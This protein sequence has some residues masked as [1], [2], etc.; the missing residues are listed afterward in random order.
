MPYFDELVP[1][2][3]AHLAAFGQLVTVTVGAASSTLDAIVSTSHSRLGYEGLSV[4]EALIVVSFASQAFSATGAGRGDSVS[5]AGIAYTIS[6]PP[7]A[8]D[9]GMTSCELR[10]S[11]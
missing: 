4:D 8:D 6:A 9:G 7:V 11:A 3:D 2:A 1:M 5:V 10:K